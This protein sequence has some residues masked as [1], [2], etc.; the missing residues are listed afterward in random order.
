MKRFATTR[1]EQVKERKI[2]WFDEKKGV[3]ECSEAGYESF[4]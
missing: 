2:V 3:R 4:I 1:D